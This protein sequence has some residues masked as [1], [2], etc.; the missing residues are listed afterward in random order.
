MCSDPF[1][2]EKENSGGTGSVGAGVGEGL[3]KKGLNENKQDLR[4]GRG[5]AGRG[6]FICT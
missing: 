2:S 3:I 5:A 6:A 4:D 1:L